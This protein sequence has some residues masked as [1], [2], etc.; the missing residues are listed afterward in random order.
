M[1]NTL[2][3]VAVTS[4]IMLAGLA[5]GG[6]S[7]DA[8]AR[9]EPLAA[10]DVSLE[11]A[12]LPTPTPSLAPTPLPTS[13]ALPPSTAEPRIVVADDTAAGVA[14]TPTAVAA[15]A[16]PVPTPILAATPVAGDQ[17]AVTDEPSAPADEIAVTDNVGTD[18]G[19]NDNVGTDTGTNGD[20][21]QRT[22]RRSG[23]D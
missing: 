13:T 4:G 5:V 21:E 6:A 16:T 11:L 8:P 3:T 7:F 9:E 18:T 19:N 14:A 23:K 12:D 20:D 17:V 15:T 2:A 10:G 22:N 1:K